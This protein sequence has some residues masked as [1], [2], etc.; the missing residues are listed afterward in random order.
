MSVAGRKA[1]L[2]LLS[3]ALGAA[4]GY[5]TLLLIGRYVPPAAYGSVLFA[6]SVTGLAAVVTNL[7][8]GAV[9]QRQVA[10]GIDVSR[11]LGAFVRIRAV[12][13]V[14]VVGLLLGAYL[15]WTRVLGRPLTDATT[16]LVLAVAMLFHA[17][18]G[19][20]QVLFDTWIGQ[21]RVHRVE[22]VRQVD[23]VLVVL[24]VANAGL[25]LAHLSGG[26][27]EPLPAVGAFWARLLGLDAPLSVAQAALL[28][29]ACYTLAKGLS[30]I[31]AWAFSLRDRVR[32]GPWD[33]GLARAYVRLAVPFALTGA[34]GLVLG[35]TDT[36]LLGFFWT[37]R[38]VGL[39]GTAQK[40]ASISLL[41]ASAVS[42]VLFARFSA[43]HAAGDVAAGDA[44]FRRAQRY[45][46]ALVVPAVAFLAAVPRTTIHVAVG[47]A[48]LDAAG[49]VRLLALCALVATL[50]QPMA[51]RLMG[52][53]R[54]RVLTGS[55]LLNT[56]LNVALNLVLL[57]RG[58]G[59]GLGVTGAAIATLASTLL[60]YAY[61]RLR[62][63]QLHGIPWMDSHQVRMLLAGLAVGLGWWLAAAT[64]PG[65][66]LRAWELLLWAGAGTLAFLAILALLG[67]LHGRDLAFL[68]KAA[69]P[70]A[71]L[72]ELLGRQG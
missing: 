65:L 46:M 40:L 49:P 31:V 18:N 68:R 1:T 58:W 10:Q 9:H 33:A 2:V 22:I 61:V 37:A 12:L 41:A 19:S 56:L 66:F 27:W 45:L 54:A 15:V 38:E 21:Q 43:L 20:R 48:Y 63:R 52:E 4:L 39:Y 72:Q 25:L 8:I 30:L 67:E 32:V 14:A 36:I 3:N 53:G 71:L 28:V 34:L 24:A 69:H 50:E 42:G 29:A 62:M 60:S 17:L 23:T 51:A 11:A 70:K 57:P 35:Y 64:W 26:R 6:L 16:P 5:A 13:G 59:L 7:G 47:D 55:A 44:L